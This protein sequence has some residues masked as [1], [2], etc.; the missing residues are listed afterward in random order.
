[1]LGLSCNTL[2]LR[3]VQG[4]SCPAAYGIL[5]P[6]PG[7]KPASFALE[8][9]FLATGPPGKSP[10]GNTNYKIRHLMQPIKTI[11]C[12]IINFLPRSRY[13]TMSNKSIHEWE[14][15]LKGNT[16]PYCQISPPY[17]TLSGLSC[18]SKSPP[19]PP[20]YPPISHLQNLFCT[21][22]PVPGSLSQFT[23]SLG[24][25]VVSDPLPAS[26]LCSWPQTPKPEQPLYSLSTHSQTVKYS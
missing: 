23:D 21:P 4:L 24:F 16:G 14:S 15:K 18:H 13:F 17:F 19:Y 7:I 10:K 12:S 9:G 11:F 3:C 22:P 26:L 5:V 2:D 8:G 25:A 20:S 6:W 1:M